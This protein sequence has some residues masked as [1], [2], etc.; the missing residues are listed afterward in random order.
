MIELY[1]IPEFIIYG[2][3]NVFCFSFGAEKNVEVD[4]KRTNKKTKWP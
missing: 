3:C 4:Q 2:Y 1:S